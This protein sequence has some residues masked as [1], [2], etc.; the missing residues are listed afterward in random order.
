MDGVDVYGIPEVVLEGR[1]GGR[2]QFR[3]RGSEGLERQAGRVVMKGGEDVGGSEVWWYSGCGMV[4]MFCERHG[5]GG[6][7]K[8]PGPRLV[9]RR[10]EAGYLAWCR[11]YEKT[12]S[13]HSLITLCEGA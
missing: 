12:P 13:I 7:A 1:G 2:R 5:G 6:D 9:V 3:V 11:V 10:I 4:V 8:K